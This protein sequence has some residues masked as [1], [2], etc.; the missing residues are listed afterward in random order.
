MNITRRKM[1]GGTD[2]AA[3]ENAIKNTTETLEVLKSMQAAPAPANP[4]DL[5]DAAAAPTSAPAPAKPAALTD[6]AANAP[7]PANSAALT[8]AAAA[9]VTE[10][11][12]APATTVTPATESSNAPAT[13]VTPA[14]TST[15][16]AESTS[17][18]AESS[19]NVSN[20]VVSD[21]KPQDKPARFTVVQQT[22]GSS[23]EKLNLDGD[24]SFNNLFL[25][26]QIT[27]IKYN[28]KNLKKTQNDPINRLVNDNTT[29][30]VA[31]YAN[32]LN[33]YLD[34]NPGTSPMVF[35]SPEPVQ[36][37]GTKKRK[38]RRR[39]MRTKRRNTMKKRNRSH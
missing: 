6:V 13:T 11:S 25:R 12:N 15:P 21:V 7:A 10:S 3:L 35:T 26:K 18:P 28:V 33:A 29:I 34:A 2:P 30:P 4:A 20:P 39:R 5:T 9:P 22:K 27:N 31:T 8:D 17:A 16:A 24:T 1:R 32:I 19:A 14:P 23:S 37:G 38:M 36:D